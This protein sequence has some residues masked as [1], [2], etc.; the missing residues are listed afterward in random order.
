M[1]KR[2]GLLKM[3][4]KL[5]CL[6][7]VALILS[8]CRT[9]TMMTAKGGTEYRVRVEATDGNQ[10]A[11]VDRTIKVM[12]SKLNAVGLYGGDVTKDTS[13]PQVII[14]KVYGN[15]D[16]ERMKKFLFTAYQLEIRKAISPP[17]P[18]PLQTYRT[19]EEAQHAARRISRRRR[20]GAFVCSC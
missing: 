1:R 7:S 10:E 9:L 17:N 14:V 4:K 20:Q 5:L 6:L 3:N 11:I 19:A 16:P 12:Q 18:Q 13:D 15:E 8:G 2:E